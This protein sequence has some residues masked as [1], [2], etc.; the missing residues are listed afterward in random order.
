MSGGR[1]RPDL[2]RVFEEG[3]LFMRFLATS[4]L[5]SLRQSPLPC[6]SSLRPWPT[7]L[8]RNRHLAM[9][10]DVKLVTY[11]VQDLTPG[12]GNLSVSN[13][14]LDATY[15]GSAGPPPPC[16]ECCA[17]QDIAFDPLSVFLPVD[18]T[19]P[20]VVDG[21]SSCNNQV[22]DISG[23]FNTWASQN[24]TI[25]QLSTRKVQGLT[26]GVTTGFANGNVPTPGACACPGQQVE[27][28]VPVTVQVP[29]YFGPTGYTPTSCDCGANSAGTCIAVSDQV[30]DQSGSAMQAAGI[31]PQELIC[32]SDGC[33]SGYNN[34]ATPATTLTT[35]AYIDT[36]IGT[37]FS[38]VP[39]NNLCVGASVSYQ[40]MFNGQKYSVTTLATGIDCVKGVKFEIYSNPQAYNQTYT[41][42]TLQ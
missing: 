40:A 39:S 4:S 35:G 6:F 11:D 30:L 27:P 22:V 1:I 3:P 21:V 25:A 7:P 12:S 26:P 13:L 19:E 24:Q 36:P 10:V 14:A 34:F 15:G 38:P 23:D 33:Q 18:G 32:R 28:T 37:C 29:T 9:P 16:P 2:A 5:Y 31:T 8:E 17:Y 20:V 42:G 41:T